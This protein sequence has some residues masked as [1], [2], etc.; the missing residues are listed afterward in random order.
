MSGLVRGNACRKGERHLNLAESYDTG[1]CNIRGEANRLVAGAV[2]FNGEVTVDLGCAELEVAALV[3][4]DVTETV[5]GSAYERLA[6][7]EVTLKPDNIDCAVADTVSRI[8]FGNERISYVGVVSELNNIGLARACSEGACA[9]GLGIVEAVERLEGSRDIV[10]L[11]LNLVG[12]SA[13][14]RNTEGSIVVALNHGVEEE[15]AAD[16]LG[17]FGIVCKYEG[18]LGCI[19]FAGSV[20]ADDLY[21]SLNVDAENLG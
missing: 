6:G 4:V 13:Y 8:D 15:L 9:D 3:N 21:A 16:A 7:C 12:D 10:A 19:L 1:V 2:L 17:F 5:V 11:K 20:V 18:Q 14:A